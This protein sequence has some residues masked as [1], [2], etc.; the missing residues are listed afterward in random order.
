MVDAFVPQDL[1]APKVKDVSPAAPKKKAAKPG[2][3]VWLFKIA[4]PQK[5]RV[6]L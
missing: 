1:Q 6:L 3:H 4:W 2:E 5:G